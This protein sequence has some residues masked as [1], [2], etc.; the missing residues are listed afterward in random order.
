MRLD[1]WATVFLVYVKRFRFEK[2]VAGSTAIVT[3]DKLVVALV[4]HRLESTEEEGCAHRIL[5][6]TKPRTSEDSL[7]ANGLEFMPGVVPHGLVFSF[8]DVGRAKA[9]L[10]GVKR[11]GEERLNA[12]SNQTGGEGGLEGR[13]RV[14][15][16]GLVGRR[17]MKTGEAVEVCCVQNGTD[18]AIVSVL[19][20][21]FPCSLA[22][23]VFAIRGGIT[24][25]GM[26]VQPSVFTACHRTAGVVMRHDH[27]AVS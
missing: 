13:R 12:S 15:A 7:W 26:K 20:G 17:N 8:K 18:A 11:C 21:G 3:S 24:W 14:C 19:R 23:K 27:L 22:Y 4:L 25:F 10:E 6:H 16:F 1:D 2:G 9:D 5:E